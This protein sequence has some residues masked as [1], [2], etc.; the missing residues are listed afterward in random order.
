M[1]LIVVKGGNIQETANRYVALDSDPA[2]PSSVI[3]EVVAVVTAMPEVER[4]ELNGFIF[5]TAQKLMHYDGI[6]YLLDIGRGF[7]EDHAFACAVTLA[8]VTF[9][10]VEFVRCPGNKRLKAIRLIPNSL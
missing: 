2:D 9:Y 7:K 10:D 6:G 4:T 5:P 3:R 1:K 8:A